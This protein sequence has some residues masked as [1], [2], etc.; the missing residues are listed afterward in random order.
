[1]VIMDW[2]INRIWLGVCRVS[3][4]CIK[5]NDARSRQKGYT[6]GWTLI[7]EKNVCH[8]TI[9]TGKIR[10]MLFHQ[11]QHQH[12]HDLCVCAHVCVFEHSLIGVVCFFVD[13]EE[14]RERETTEPKAFPFV[15]ISSLMMGDSN[16]VL[17]FRLTNS[18]IDEETCLVQPSN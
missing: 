10:R 5:L 9:R 6:C 2:A 16:Q 7:K 4:G 8:E 13:I 18:I 1:M 3:F 17:P 12:R 15:F 11:H 14:K